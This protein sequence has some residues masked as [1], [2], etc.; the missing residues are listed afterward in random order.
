[1]E[2]PELR[3]DCGHVL[4]GEG[5]RGDGGAGVRGV[6]DADDGGER[7]VQTHPVVQPDGVGLVPGKDEDRLHLGERVAE[8]VARLHR[9]LVA[10]LVQARAP[11]PELLARLPDAFHSGV[12]IGELVT[13]REQAVELL[14][15]LVEARGGTGVVHDLAR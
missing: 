12:E 15:E 4:V 14:L 8:R 1:M 6:D 10:G 2:A 9:I 3:I 7:R 5:E 11:A 13:D